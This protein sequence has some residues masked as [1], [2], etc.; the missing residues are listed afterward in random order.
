MERIR[1][2]DEDG[3]R[4]LLRQYGP[5]MRYVIAPILPDEQD[6]EECVYEAALRVWEKIDTFQPQKG[7]WSGWLTAICRNAALN[8]VRGAKVAAEPLAQDIPATAASP[9]EQLL[10]RERQA[11]LLRALGR[12]SPGDRALFYRKY[13]Y[14]QPTAQIAAELGLTERAVEGRL[15]RLRKRLRRELGGDFYD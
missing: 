4:A 5:L 1:H 3:M 15:Y 2:R 12:L 7:S 11:A 6:R 13:Y 14:L 10:R 9:E 8:R